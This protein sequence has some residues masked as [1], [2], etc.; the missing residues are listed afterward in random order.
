MK[1]V[2]ADCIFQTIV[3]MQKADCDFSK[4]SQLRYK[5]DEVEKNKPSLSDCF[6]RGTD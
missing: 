1:R 5:C 6:H 4:E 2:K 3:F